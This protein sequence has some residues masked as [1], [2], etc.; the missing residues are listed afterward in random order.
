MKRHVTRYVTIGVVL[1]VLLLASSVICPALAPYTGDPHKT[2]AMAFQTGGPLGLGYDYLGRPI[3]PQL[4]LGGRSLF[5][6]SLITATLSLVLSIAAGLVLAS[7]R[8][9]SS[10][11]RFL[12]DALLIIPVVVGSLIGFTISKGNLYAII[13]IT[14]VLS[15]PFMSRYYQSLVTPLMQ[16]A[17]FEQARVAGDSTFKALIREI[18]P[19]L[20]RT[21]FTDFGVLFIS[22]VYV[23]TTVTFISGKSQAEVFLWSSMASSNLPG[24]A[25]NPWATIAPVICILLL[26]VPLNLA[27]SARKSGAPQ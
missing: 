5:I 12:L 23:L 21:V 16:S 17:F 11:L 19:V 25:L 8:Y 24:I 14:V 7:T 26:T 10:V 22:A 20:I 15:I 4:L 13:P 2:V 1:L 9:V 6:A 3:L 18:L 27:F